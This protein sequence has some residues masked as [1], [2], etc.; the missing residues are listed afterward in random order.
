VGCCRGISTATC[1]NFDM[2][3]RK[4]SIAMTYKKIRL[5]EQ[6]SDFLFWQTQPYTSRLEAL[7]QIRQQYIAWKYDTRPRFQRVFTI[8]KQK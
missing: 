6:E 4:R 5:D 7:E 3:N 8:I 1:Y 2:E